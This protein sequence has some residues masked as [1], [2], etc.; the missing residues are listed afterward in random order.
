MKSVKNI[1]LFVNQSLQSES[2]VKL[3]E[4]QSHYLANVMRCGLGDMLRCFNAKDGEFFCVVE[5]ID[6][7]EAILKIGELSRIAE[8]KSDIW[9]AFAPLKKDKTDFVIEKAVE[10]GVSKII[11]VITR[12]T[13]AE[14]V[15]IERLEAQAI[16]AA[17]QCGRLSVPMV[18]APVKLGDMLAN[19][20]SDRVLFFLDER[21]EGGNAVQTF[22][23]N[24]GRP[25]AVLIGPEGGFDD[26]E[27]QKINACAFVK[28]LSLGPRILRAE[29]AAVASLAV[30]QA[31]AGDWYSAKE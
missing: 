16:E 4:K 10:L 5:K 28:N 12:Y 7:K 2:L 31:A 19:W 21:R 11:P 23:E 26:D 1:R 25:V 9:L 8:E 15:K 24:R 27:A 22:F 29:T 20:N 30:W 6:K 13:N 3:S 18:V 14:K 17:E